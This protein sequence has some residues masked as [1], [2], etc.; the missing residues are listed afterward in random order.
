[1]EHT[2][3]NL[4]QQDIALD[5]GHIK[6]VFGGLLTQGVRALGVWHVP[7]LETQD[8]LLDLF[9]T[10]LGDAFGPWARD[11]WGQL[12]SYIGGA[13]IWV[14]VSCRLKKN[15]SLM[16]G[17]T[18]RER[19]PV[20]DFEKRCLEVKSPRLLAIINYHCFAQGQTCL[21]IQ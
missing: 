1:M 6:G 2:P 20:N 13:L 14:R 5:S 12:L 16:K 7:F 4:Y 19:C 18:L 3:S 15:W 8:A 21:D 10:E 11:G 9:E 17:G